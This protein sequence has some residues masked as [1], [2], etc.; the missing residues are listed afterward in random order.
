MRLFAAYGNR[1]R[2]EPD[3]YGKTGLASRARRLTPPMTA[4]RIR[5]RHAPNLRTAPVRKK[6]L[7]IAPCAAFDS[8]DLRHTDRPK[9]AKDAPPQVHQGLFRVT[10][11]AEPHAR[12]LLDLQG[13]VEAH[14]ETTRA[15]GRAHGR[16]M[17]RS[18]PRAR[19]AA[20][21]ASTT[22]ATYPLQPA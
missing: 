13:H 8:L 14:F 20:T 22:P 15:D 11:D 6:A 12:A 17:S 19:S 16:A 21:A 9:L 4:A 7:R 5:R 3:C 10:G 2:V 18:A 1:A